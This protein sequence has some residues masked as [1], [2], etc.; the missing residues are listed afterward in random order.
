MSLCQHEIRT[1]ILQ[2]RWNEKS[3]ILLD[4]ILC[5]ANGVILRLYCRA[6]SCV[7]VCACKPWI[8]CAKRAQKL[9][10]Q[11]R[12]FRSVIVGFSYWL[13]WIELAHVTLGAF[14]RDAGNRTRDKLHNACDFQM[15]INWNVRFAILKFSFVSWRFFLKTFERKVTFFESEEYFCSLFIRF[16]II[17]RLCVCILFECMFQM[18]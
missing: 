16:S 6:Y 15:E 9:K 11:K 1:W 10:L 2:T 17:I 7:C 18:R 14:N 8:Y 3:T 4:K 13:H 12:N 5:Y